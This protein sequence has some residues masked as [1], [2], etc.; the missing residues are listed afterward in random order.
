M[1]TLEAKIYIQENGEKRE[2]TGQE[3]FD[4]LAQLALDNASHSEQ[5]ALEEALKAQKAALLDRLGITAEEAK[6]LLA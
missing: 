5:L 2:L 1:A 4:Y 6:L 3:K